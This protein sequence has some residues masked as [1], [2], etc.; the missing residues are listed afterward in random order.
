MILNF[1]LKEQQKQ[2]IVFF[3]FLTF[4]KDYKKKKEVLT[5]TV[6]Q[7]LHKTVTIDQYS[8]GFPDW[9]LI[10]SFWG[11]HNFIILHKFEERAQ[12]S[13]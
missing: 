8:R 10:V 1:T 6:L 3:Y 4:E 13:K 2:N 9:S 5:E 12:L 11:E 7:S